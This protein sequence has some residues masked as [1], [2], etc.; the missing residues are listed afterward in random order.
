M[1]SRV[2]NAT[3]IRRSSMHV[4]SRVHELSGRPHAVIWDVAKSYQPVPLMTQTSQHINN[5]NNQMSQGSTC[6]A[7]PLI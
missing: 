4:A 5:D 2:R 6:Y 3:S 1:A 7:R